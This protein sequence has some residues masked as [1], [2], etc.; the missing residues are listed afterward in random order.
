MSR[1]NTHYKRVIRRRGRTKFARCG[2]DDRFDPF[3]LNETKRVSDLYDGLFHSFLGDIGC[4]RLLDIGCGTGIYFRS[5]AKYAG[6]IEAIDFSEDMLSV[7]RD[8][9]TKTG[10]SNI[11]L[12]SASADSLPYADESFDVVI[13]M[14]LLHHVADIGQTLD[15]VYRVLK[16]GG[17]F[18][19]FEPNVC[20]PL[21]F[22]AHLIPSEERLA[23]SRNRPRKLIA[24]LTD[25]FEPVRWEGICELVTQSKG[26]KAIILDAYLKAWKI[27][28]LGKWF[29]RQ[30]WLG[31][32]NLGKQR[33]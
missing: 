13:T 22:V 1:S 16:H 15:E 19:V 3:L 32:K 8:Y 11:H 7:A 18:F 24:V 33:I 21:M 27:T 17:H 12:Q 23:L 9:C 6:E 26:M 31:R 5:L 28:G 4:E 10:L 29:P 30:A 20:N 14:D 25:R 2:Y